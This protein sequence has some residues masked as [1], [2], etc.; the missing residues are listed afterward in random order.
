MKSGKKMQQGSMRNIIK[1][2][3]KSRK[4]AHTALLY[5]RG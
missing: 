2:L 1:D 5:S 3:F 4:Q